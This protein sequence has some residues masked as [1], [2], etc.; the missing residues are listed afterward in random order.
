MVSDKQYWFRAKRC[1]WGWGLPSRW[2]G[3]AV[4]VAFVALL[5]LGAFAFR[6]TTNSARILALSLCGAPF[7]S[8]W[9][10]RRVSPPMEVGS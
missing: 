10:G 2:Q 7:C 1:C 5:S 4:L 3:W 8:P 6:L 9:L